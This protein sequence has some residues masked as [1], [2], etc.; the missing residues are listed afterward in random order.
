MEVV[1]SVLCSCVTR[2]CIC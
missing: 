1:M 2:N